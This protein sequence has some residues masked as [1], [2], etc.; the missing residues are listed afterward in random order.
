M[1]NYYFSK[2]K[3]VLRFWI[4]S[5]LPRLRIHTWGGFGSQLFSAYLI[6]RLRE[7]LPGR[8]LVVVNHSSGVTRRLMELDFGLLNVES[9]QIDDFSTRISHSNSSSN[10]LR[11]NSFIYQI[12]A[13]TLRFVI[14]HL[15]FLNSAN[16]EASLSSIRPWT[17][18]LRGHYTRLLMKRNSVDALYRLIFDRVDI[19]NTKQASCVIHY[20]LGDL[21]SLGS[22]SPIQPS[23]IENTLEEYGLIYKVPLVLTDSNESQYFQFV[24]NTQ[25]LNKIQ[26]LNLDAFHTLRMCVHSNEFLGTTAKISLWAAIFR[27][28]VLGKPS[29]LPSELGWASESGVHPTWY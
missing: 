7:I 2:Y 28:F 9:I 21:I 27:Q 13:R 3:N 4:Y 25:Y 23:R 29:L 24:S 17:L 10:Q 6:L 1:K 12:A 18:S 15:K 26:P 5:K 8:R 19:G 22:K 20:R 11:I 16:D 14:E